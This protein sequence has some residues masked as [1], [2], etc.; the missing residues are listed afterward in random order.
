MQRFHRRS[1][2]YK[3][4][5]E[6]GQPFP[7]LFQE[8]DS[9]LRMLSFRLSFVFISPTRSGVAVGLHGRGRVGQCG[10][11]SESQARLSPL[12]TGS[13]RLLFHPN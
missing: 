12:T 9:K 7:S 10:S 2:V 13:P 6:T 8:T 1:D 5:K 11:E 4:Q 3:T